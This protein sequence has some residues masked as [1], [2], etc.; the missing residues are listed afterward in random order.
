VKLADF[1]LTEL[2][3]KNEALRAI[4]NEIEDSLPSG[5]FLIKKI[6]DSNPFVARL[7]IN[8]G[9]YW[10]YNPIIFVAIDGSKQSQLKFVE[11]VKEILES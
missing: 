4:I 10:E 6:H 5:K 11:G 1:D 3:K 8:R 9:K 2:C 7:V